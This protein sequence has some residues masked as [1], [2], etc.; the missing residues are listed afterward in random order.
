MSRSSWPPHTLVSLERQLLMLSDS[1]ANPPMARSDDEEVWLTRFLLLRAV[2]YLEQVVHDC[3]RGHIQESSYGTVR[4]FSI[5]WMDRSRNPSVENLLTLLGRLDLRLRDDFER[6]IDE[7]DQSLRRD[8]SAA[9]ARRHQIAHGL[10]E[11]IGRSRALEHVER[12]REI[13]DWF[14]RNLNPNADG[15]LSRQLP[16]SFVNSNWFSWPSELSRTVLRLCP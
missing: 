14:I 2:G 13:A 9:V 1:V 6:W 8:L 7:D 16:E 3:V 11:G 12:L 5:S 10:N 4:N 15:R